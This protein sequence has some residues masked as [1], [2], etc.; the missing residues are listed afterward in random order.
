MNVDELTWLSVTCSSK[1]APHGGSARQGKADSAGK[2]QPST[3]RTEPSRADPRK[4]AHRATA[5]PRSGPPRNATGPSAISVAATG[6]QVVE[7]SPNQVTGA[8]AGIGRGG[9]SSV[10]TTNSMVHNVPA[11]RGTTQARHL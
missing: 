5:T 10:S 8:S 1:M 9:K 4:G 6:S 3:S 11:T 2:A 7:G